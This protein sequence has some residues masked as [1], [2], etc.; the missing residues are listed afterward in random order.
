MDNGYDMDELVDDT[1]EPFV[2]GVDSVSDTE[3][4]NGSHFITMGENE[5][6]STFASVITPSVTP[7]T[8][9]QSKKRGRQ[10]KPESEKKQRTS[11]HPKGMLRISLTPKV[12][13]PRGRPPR[14]RNSAPDSIVPVVTDVG[15]NSPFPVIQP[16]TPSPV[17][18]K[19]GRPRIHPPKDPSV[20]KPRGRPRK[21]PLEGE[22]AWQAEC[23]KLRRLLRKKDELIARMNQKLNELGA[24]LDPVEPESDGAD[25]GDAMNGS[26]QETSLVEETLP[27]SMED[28]HQTYLDMFARENYSDSAANDDDD[29][30]DED[31][32]GQ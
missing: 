30:D 28:T 19:L 1:D 7:T 4:G 12:K 26:G 15:L 10:P 18:K 24:T 8:T 23:N 9:P 25:N 6:V 32:L 13:G 2:G 3:D 17:K 31:E 5:H 22:K 27:S 16:S 11:L 29:D 14:S 21:V 20:K